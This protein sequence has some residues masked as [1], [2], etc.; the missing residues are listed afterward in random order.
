M[1][2]AFLSDPTPYASYHNAA[3]VFPDRSIPLP[4]PADKSGWLQGLARRWH[5]ERRRR[6]VGRAYDMALEIARLIPR[7]S[8]VID[9]GCGSGYIAHHLS[10]LLGARVLGMDVN[11]V[12]EAPVDFKSFDG[13]RFPVADQSLDAAIFCYVLHHAQ[14]LETLMSELRRV[15]RDGGSAVVYE[16]IPARWWDRVVCRAHDLK[17]RKRTGPC[18]FRSE[19]VWRETFAENGFEVVKEKKLSRWRNLAHPVARR[20]FVLRRAPLVSD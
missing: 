7:N 13:R 3:V 16:D 10:A 6:K 9:V 12:V 15:L 5:R 14:D 2:A 11:E 19:Y 8:S 17:W 4:A 20:L 1:S 18:T